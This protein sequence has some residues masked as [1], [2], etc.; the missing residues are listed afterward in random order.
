MRRTCS[1]FALGYFYVQQ[2]YSWC[3][4]WREVP[5]AT[6]QMIK[7]YIHKWISF[8]AINS[9]LVV[10][11]IWLSALVGSRNICAWKLCTG[12]GMC[13]L[14]YTNKPPIYQQKLSHPPKKIPR[15]L[16][17]SFLVVMDQH[18]HLPIR[19]C[20]YVRITPTHTAAFASVNSISVS[21][22]YADI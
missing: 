6:K 3:Y 18:R 13:V 8:A 20:R 5:S 9:A 7:N 1:L 4:W 11:I 15:R 16:C 21:F 10:K 12:T 2:A 19:M 14:L 17:V 22:L